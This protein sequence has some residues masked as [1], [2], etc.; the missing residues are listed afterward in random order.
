MRNFFILLVVVFVVA[1]A[2]VAYW[3]Q[4]RIHQI[5]QPSAA[6]GTATIGG[7]FAL[8]DQHGKT[9]TDKDFAGR[10]MLVFFG[11]TH[12]PDICPTA[13]GTITAAR[14]KLGEQQKSRLV[15]IFITVDPSRDT[16]EVMK[17]FASHFDKDLVALTGS[18]ADTKKAEDAYKVYATNSKGK[19]G[20]STINHSGYIYLMDK[21]G[22]YLTHFSSDVPE[23]TLAEAL[24]GAVK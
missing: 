14:S 8:T 11:F 16:P 15:P 2:A 22:N 21:Q 17:E 13:L 6:A 7:S 23:T 20:E 3:Q 18:E 1:T 12:C 9:V 19:D 5:P 4:Q 10:Y 24:K